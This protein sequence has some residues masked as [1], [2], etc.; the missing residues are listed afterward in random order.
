ML[1]RNVINYIVLVFAYKYTIFFQYSQKCEH[2]FFMHHQVLSC[3]FRL[4]KTTANVPPHSLAK[5][6][7]T[8][9]CKKPIGK[10]VHEL[11]DPW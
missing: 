5:H 8:R 9:H 1:L 2:S 11:H 4:Y 7:I 10:A 6:F 3:F